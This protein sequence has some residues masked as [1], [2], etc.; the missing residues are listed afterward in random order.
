MAHI[1]PLYDD[2]HRHAQSLLPWHANGAL[3]A[4]ERAVLDA[5][6]DEC[7][8]CRRDLKLEE[9]LA[10]AVCDLPAQDQAG[11]M[12]GHGRMHHAPPSF[13]TAARG[14]VG[15]FFRRR[16][17][18]GLMFAAQ[19]AMLVLCVGVVF[20]WSAQS[21]PLYRALGSDSARTAGNIVVIFKP[22]T[23]EQEL[24]AALVQ[25]G[26]RI[27]DGPTASDA[28]VLRT[29]PERRETALVQLRRNARVA[30]AEPLDPGD[31]R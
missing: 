6:L 25:S 9:A 3:G 29:P 8:E 18:V 17:S 20:A 12:G 21:R 1:I 23:S 14:G 28:F 13:R 26:A 19:A 4:E 11:W 24:R 5:H 30:L 2:P 31:L 15:A 7:A 22:T 27:V 10:R 16:V